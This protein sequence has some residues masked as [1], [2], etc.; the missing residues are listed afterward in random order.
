MIDNTGP[1]PTKINASAARLGEDDPYYKD[2]LIT[3]L[4]EEIA[5]LQERLAQSFH[6][7]IGDLK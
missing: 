2:R 4:R 3:A 6:H 7:D 5:R 1:A